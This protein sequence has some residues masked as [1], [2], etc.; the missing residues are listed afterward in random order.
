MNKVW[1]LI[2]LA[3]C[4]STELG[5]EVEHD[6]SN[7]DA[8]DLNVLAPRL[9]SGLGARSDTAQELAIYQWVPRECSPWL[10]SCALNRM[11][12]S[13]EGHQEVWSLIKGDADR[14]FETSITVTDGNDTY[15]ERV[16]LQL[17]ERD[18]F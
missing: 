18:N 13:C 5:T 4:A 7:L 11:K 6:A 16:L 15:E 8:C 14:G 9:I 10:Y 17:T 1:L 2:V 12:L 3:G